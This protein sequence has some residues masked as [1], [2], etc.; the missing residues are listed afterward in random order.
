MIS[1]VLGNRRLRLY[2]NGVIESR[3]FSNLG[4]E[5]QNE[6]WQ[7]I[8]FSKHSSGYMNCIHT[9]DGVRKNLLEHRM[10]IT[11]TIK[12]G[13]FGIRQWII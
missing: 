2:P 5:T 1:F 8:K 9:I 10:F 13:I 7:P 11:L 6:K 4:V 12:T 3:A